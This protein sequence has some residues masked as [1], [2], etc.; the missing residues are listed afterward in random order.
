MPNPR[1]PAR[2]MAYNIWL[3]SQGRRPLTDIAH[4]C[5]VSAGQ[6]RKWKSVDK[7]TLE[8]K[9]KAEPVVTVAPAKKAS[10]NSN[11]KRVN[12]NGNRRKPKR[13][14]LKP[15]N[16]YGNPNLQPAPE[17]NK[18]AVTAGEYET[19]M[20]DTLTDTEKQLAAACLTLPAAETLL[21]TLAVLT[22]RE[23]RIMERIHAR[24]ALSGESTQI[25]G[26]EMFAITALNIKAEDTS[27]TVHKKQQVA[28]EHA[29]S[30]INDL[31]DALTRVQNSKAK[32]LDMLH[33]MQRD[34]ILT[35]FERRK[36]EAMEQRAML[37][38][39]RFEFEYAH[40]MDGQNDPVA[41]WL[42]A[43]RPSTEDVTALFIVDEGDAQ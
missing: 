17:G 8:G 30:F 37:E 24:M 5:G 29:V 15:G 13:A 26:S 34:A 32:V 23:H 35:D 40:G 12:G 7:W 27:G 39:K 42:N 38:Q 33:R 10:G 21:R 36:V 41:D 16:P 3:G 18:R 31:E 19:I 2:E 14:K 20:F 1:S 43:T 6:I 11:T 9:K 4:E 22:V 25:S 28:F